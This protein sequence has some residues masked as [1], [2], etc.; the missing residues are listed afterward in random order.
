MEK[1]T[2][3]ETILWKCD[4]CI[5]S[6]KQNDFTQSY[7]LKQLTITRYPKILCLHLHRLLQVNGAQRKIDNFVQFDTNLDLYPFTTAFKGNFS[8]NLRTEDNFNKMNTLFDSSIL[9]N[10]HT[11]IIY[12]L[13]AII[14]HLGDASG[15]HYVVY[16]RLLE[17]TSMDNSL[18]LRKDCWVLISD[19]H[20]EIVPESHVL[21]QRAY[22][23]FYERK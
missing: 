18:K 12:S 21:K 2:E 14:V 11:S 1:Y 13:V 10:P 20:W 5:K 15:G 8:D 6:P 3:K 16:K 9:R 19:S 23:L 22:L 17:H 4:E 7:G